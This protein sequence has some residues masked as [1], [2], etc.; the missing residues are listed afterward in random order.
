MGTL[1]IRTMWQAI[2]KKMIF[3]AGWM[4]FTPLQINFKYSKALKYTLIF[5]VLN[6]V[7]KIGDKCI[8]R[9][10]SWIFWD[11]EK[12]AHF[13]FQQSG[14]PWKKRD[15][16]LWGKWISTEMNLS[17]NVL[18]ESQL[19][20]DRKMSVCFCPFKEFRYCRKAT[21][22]KKKYPTKPFSHWPILGWNVS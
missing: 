9:Q 15:F 17:C 4:V 10:F 13:E 11:H 14:K 22:S 20:P 5:L 7:Q 12:W 2:G 1:W 21:K 19:I 6:W 16:F 18:Y 3:A 8:L